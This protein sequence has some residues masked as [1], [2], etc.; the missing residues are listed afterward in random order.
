MNIADRIAANPLPLALAC[1]GL[2][3][4]WQW[5]F[6][7]EDG[8][9]ATPE[10]GETAGDGGASAPV[11]EVP[12]GGEG[13]SLSS[14]YGGTPNASSAPAVSLGDMWEPAAGTTSAPPPNKPAPAGET[15]GTVSP[16][17]VARSKEMPPVYKR[18]PIESGVPAL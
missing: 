10:Q 12:E 8:A 9:A 6:Q 15:P 7:A 4:G 13:V 18:S 14:L 1:L 5:I 11:N 2:Y 17:S 3:L 16:A